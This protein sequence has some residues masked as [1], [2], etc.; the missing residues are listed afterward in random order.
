MMVEFTTDSF[1]IV[2]LIGIIITSSLLAKTIIDYKRDKLEKGGVIL[3]TVIWG[4]A[5][6]I[7]LIPGL[8]HLVFELIAVESVV[9]ISLVF[10]NIFLFVLVF[11]LYEK[12]QKAEKKFKLFVQNLALESAKNKDKVDTSREEDKDD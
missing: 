3:W 12:S 6:V 9:L 5:L 2:Q 4:A 8:A 1:T 7:F 10:T 11:L